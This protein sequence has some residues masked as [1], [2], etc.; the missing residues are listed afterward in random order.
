MII[1]IQLY[2]KQADIIIEAFRTDM[3]ENKYRSFKG[4]AHFC[5]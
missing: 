2:C 5:R 1:F 3:N 4:I